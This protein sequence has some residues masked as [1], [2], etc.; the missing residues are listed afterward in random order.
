MKKMHMPY[1]DDGGDE[2]VDDDGDN[3]DV[4]DV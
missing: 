2:S 4:E 1:G 3:D